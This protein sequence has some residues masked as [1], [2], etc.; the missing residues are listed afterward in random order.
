M[1]K[2][3]MLAVKISNIK[4]L[5][6]PLLAS[7]KFDGIRALTISSQLVSRK[8]KPI[9]N[10]HIRKLAKGL[11]DNLDGELILNDGT[12]AGAKF[13]ETSSAV[14]GEDGE[15]N[16]RYLIFDYVKGALT[17]PAIQR[18]KDLQDY[19]GAA[20]A[21]G[22]LVYVAQT[23]INNEAELLD[24][25]ARCL[26]NGFEGAMIRS[27]NGPYKEG[28]STEAEGYLLK[29]KRFNDAEATIVG[30]EEKMH[31][32]NEKEEDAFGHAKRSQKKEGLVPAGTL[33]KFYVKGIVNFQEMEFEIGTGLDDALRLEIWKHK[34]KYLG[35]V[36]KYKYQKCGMKEKP[37]F[38][39]F[40]G[41]RDEIDL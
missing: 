32:E 12:I 10:S 21:K 33:G 6:Y 40:L 18:Q 23:I 26:A 5:K 22:F 24:Y 13:G 20:D 19:I 17:K 25:E 38:P 3:P 7:P 1:I 9:P 27:M 29:L 31:N 16:V 28:R 11:P 35:K 37:R 4:A 41:F 34:S 8:F 36:V 15:P 2:K 30:F 39:V 14:M